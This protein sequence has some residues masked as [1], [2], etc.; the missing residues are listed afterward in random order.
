MIRRSILLATLLL[1]PLSAQ[2]AQV[3]DFNF[4][5]QIPGR[6][7]GV[8]WSA[9][10]A[11]QTGDG[12]HLTA[13]EDGAIRTALPGNFR[14]ESLILTTTA[15]REEQAVFMWQEAGNSGALVHLPVTIPQS[16]SPSVT[17]I[18]L[19]QYPQWN[20]DTQEIAIGLPAGSEM[21]LVDLSLTRYTFAEHIEWA[22]KSFFQFDKLQIFSINFLW[23]PLIGFT[24]EQYQSLFQGQPPVA[25]SAMRFVYIIL[26]IALLAWL[27]LRM[28]RKPR[29]ASVMLLSTF[30][31]LWLV[32]DLR[33]SGELISYG[34][35]DWQTWILPT[36]DQKVF[37]DRLYYY[38][39]MLEAVPWLQE[40]PTYGLLS[41]WPVTGNIRYFTVPSVPIVPTN[42]QGK[43]PSR[44]FVFSDPNAAVDAQGMLTES[45]KPV[46]GPGKI[47][48]QL[49]P[50]TFLFQA[51]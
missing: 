47:Y 46:A 7:E 41:P 3:M 39:T 17:R 33:M 6:W 22:V 5:G 51:Q 21:T 31:A 28:R 36:E 44:W 42:I 9:S 16:S 8:T 10:E 32:S 4:K 45:G 30:C 11:Q 24:P 2:A 12:L 35:T 13:K 18:D 43:P 49:G 14:A 27:V 48:K 1:L 40:S 50:S 20:P 38:R 25:I 15:P 29:L 37:R 34:V 26:A 23:G 19:T